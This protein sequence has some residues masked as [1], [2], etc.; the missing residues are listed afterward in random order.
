MIRKA[1]FNL[2]KFIKE[3]ES[4]QQLISSLEEE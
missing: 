2:T 4:L 1:Y 3:R